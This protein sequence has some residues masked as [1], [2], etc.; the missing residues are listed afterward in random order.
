MS[1]WPATVLLA[2]LIGLLAAVSLV[3]LPAA[4]AP[5]TVLFAD[6]GT[7]IAEGE[8]AQVRNLYGFNEPEHDGTRGFRWT[9]GEGR[10]VLRHAAQIDT[11]PVLSLSLCGCRAGDAATRQLDLWINGAPIVDL[12]P[13]ARQP[14]WRT[15]QLLVP[16]PPL[17]YAPDVLVELRGDSVPN[18]A[19]GYAMGVAVEQIRIAPAGTVAAFA[20][21]TSLLLGVGI[22]LLVPLTRWRGERAARVLLPALLIFGV[23]VVQGR[24]YPPQALS[25]GLLAGA[26][27]L[28]GALAVVCATG[29]WRVALLAVLGTLV[30]APQRLGAWI[31]DDAYISFRYAA[32][33]LRGDGWVFNP[34]ERVE[35]YTNFLW[36]A[37]FVPIQAITPDPTRAA[38]ALTLAI[39]LA[40]VALL[41]AATRQIAGDI[42][43]MVAAT[44]LSST[45]AYVLWSARGSGMETALFTLLM[46]ATILVLTR[47]SAARQPA[48]APALRHGEGAGLLPLSVSESGLGGEVREF[49]HVSA[50]LICGA[51]ALTR[52]E[53]ALVAAICGLWLL[54]TNGWRGPVWRFSLAFLL[55]FAPYFLWRYSYYG[56]PLP[57]TFYA[58]VGATGAQVARGVAYLRSFA[59]DHVLLMVLALVALALQRAARL[60]ALVVVVY[61]AYIVAVGGDHFPSYRFFV[62]LLPLLALLGGLAVAALVDLRRI[63]QVAGRGLTAVSLVLAL[64]QQLPQHAASQ[65]L[66]GFG[67]VWSEQSVVEKN[68]D[69]GLWLRDATA[70]DTLVATGIAGALPFYSGR[71]TIDILGL[72]DLHIAHTSVPTMGQGVAGSEKTDTTY[73]LGR[74][75]AYIPANSAGAFEPLPAFTTQYERIIVRGPEGR[76]PRLYRRRD[77]PPL[78]AEW[79]PAP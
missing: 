21:A 30:V 37:L 43:A 10:L 49:R 11:P 66:R 62:P 48:A 23:I 8:T 67:P 14:G 25:R 57:N 1:R 17:A 13:L 72:N 64:G 44:L 60:P 59:T 29:W 32:N 15:Y 77:L 71:T 56:Y 74:R 28:G 24:W 26:W 6:L 7:F 69:I 75:P 41:F 73:V 31:I 42:A 76:W 20:P 2:L 51:A 16:P 54:A 50:G 47:A 34:D 78:Q 5:I 70:P 18:A 63:W 58:K 35:G 53:G 68:R 19:F 9:S 52:P 40:T 46:T 79:Y 36:T 55:I 12:A 45:S 65:I 39:A 38:Q 22:A 61:G 4:R 27:L 33:A 3:M